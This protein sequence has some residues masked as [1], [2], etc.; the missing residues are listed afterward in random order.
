MTDSTYIRNYGTKKVALNNELHMGG[1]KITNLATPSAS[2][3]AATKGYVDSAGSPG[4]LT[5]ANYSPYSETCDSECQGRGLTC[6]SVGP[7]NGNENSVD[8]PTR[9]DI[10]HSH[11]GSGDYYS[12]NWKCRCC[13]VE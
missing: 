3:D 5:C 2:T 10:N 7:K 9:C 13:E 11:S 12:G 8:H 6:V 4:S 1:K